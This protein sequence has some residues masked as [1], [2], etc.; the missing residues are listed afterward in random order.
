MSRRHSLIRRQGD[1]F[2]IADL[3]SRN[4]T[5]VNEVKLDPDREHRLTSRRPD[6][7]LRSRVHLL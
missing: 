5:K 1:A 6:Q 3:H 7:Y 4:L 2:F